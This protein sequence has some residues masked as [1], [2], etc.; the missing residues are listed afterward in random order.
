[1]TAD[2]DAYGSVG[3]SVSLSADGNTVLFG[4]PGEN[5]NVGAT[6]LFTRSG[7]TWSQVGSKW[8]STGYVGS[9]QQGSSVGLSG[10]G[11][12][13][14]VGGVL[15]NTKVAWIFTLPNFCDA[16][17]QIRTQCLTVSTSIQCRICSSNTTSSTPCK[18]MLLVY[19]PPEFSVVVGSF[20]SVVYN[21]TNVWD[22]TLTLQYNSAASFGSV[23]VANQVTLTPNT[24]TSVT[25]IVNVGSN[26]ETSSDVMNTT[27]PFQV[28][29]TSMDTLQFQIPISFEMSTFLST[30]ES[31]SYVMNLGQSSQTTTLEPL[32]R[33]S[34]YN[35]Q[36]NS[37]VIHQTIAE[38]N[39]HNIANWLSFSTNPSPLIPRTM[40]RGKQLP[41]YVDFILSF[42]NNDTKILALVGNTSVAAPT[43]TTCFIVNANLVNLGVKVN[44]TVTVDVKV[45]QSC[46]VGMSS[47][48]G[49]NDGKG[50]KVCDTPGSYQP[51]IGQTACLQCPAGKF[52]LANRT[53]CAECPPGFFSTDGSD[54][55][56]PCSKGTYTTSSNTKVCLTCAA[57]SRVTRNG[58]SCDECPPGF[59]SVDGSDM[60]LPCPLGTFTSSSNTKVCTTCS[61]G[62]RVTTNSSKCEVCPPGTFS[63]DG[64][65]VCTLC[66]I[67]KYSNTNASTAC[68]ACPESTRTTFAMGAQTLSECVPDKEQ[69]S[70]MDNEGKP[71]T[72]PIGA[73]CNQVGLTIKTLM[74]K[75]KYWRSSNESLDIRECL[76]KP[77]FCIGGHT[78]RVSARSLQ[79]VPNNN[80]TV[81]NNNTTSTTQQQ[82]DVCYPHHTGIYC[83]ACDV[84]YVHRGPDRYCM[85][86]DDA[87]REN[88]IN[89]IGGI[90]FGLFL[91]IIAV[92]GLIPTRILAKKVETLDGST[93]T[94]ASK[95]NKM[96]ESLDI[97]GE[98]VKIVI[99]F[100]Q[101]V[102]AM[103]VSF[104]SYL[105]DFF[106]SVAG[107]L[108]VL[109]FDLSQ[110]VDFGCAVPDQSHFTGLLISTLVPFGVACIVWLT[111]Q[112]TRHVV[113]K[114]R[115]ELIP[116]LNVAVNTIYLWIAFLVYPGVSSKILRTFNCEEFDDGSRALQSDATVDCNSQR[117]QQY[118]G[119]AVFM[120]LIYVVGIPVTFFVLLKRKRKLLHM[121]QWAKL[122]PDDQRTCLLERDAIPEIQS[123]HF[124][125]QSYNPNAY[126]YEIFDLLRKLAQTSIFVL[127]SK[128]S[129]LQALF[130]MWISIVTMSVLS[131]IRPYR[132]ASIGYLASW[133]QL[134][135]LVIAFLSFVNTYENRE[136]SVGLPPVT[137]GTV[138]NV[139]LVLSFFSV[140][141]YALC[142]K[143]YDV[144][145]T[146]KYGERFLLQHRM[147]AKYLGKNNEQQQ[148]QQDNNNR[149]QDNFINTNDVVL[150]IHQKKDDV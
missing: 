37:S 79:E 55:C 98:Q 130:V 25:V 31:F 148:N 41:H 61:A 142:S 101:V 94:T 126:W 135:I 104:S 112:I 113:E 17:S 68:T 45:L 70:Y 128:F 90:I 24:W 120:F 114:R 15:S 32:P 77:K 35:T 87:N 131:V 106:K 85:E 105:P 50:C 149:I 36:S 60:C 6:W 74:I 78:S 49:T 67:G 11:T 33:V 57:G 97:G 18:Q 58:T 138:T 93:R 48:S 21:I 63:A 64:S 96:L 5:S 81:N 54:V 28:T 59:F 44:R 8:V 144:I 107:A 129:P 143:L 53:G 9:P 122:S 22:T 140:P 65:D 71:K 118:L 16:T 82:N 121:S 92:L 139:I 145:I 89:K 42:P 110:F 116:D 133:S 84:G 51:A 146:S 29:I 7:T 147:V 47:D 132:E 76:L 115:P 108:G 4:G 150:S 72:C 123:L 19:S 136:A 91:A 127:V 12:T 13:A 34:V 27:F 46:P 83:Q 119:Y 141:V 125:W 23:S 102:S 10:D 40:N 66:E 109:A 62:S 124:L 56:N 80:D 137:D 26:V 86:C 100:L 20:A 117:Y 69:N 1:V 75:P 52:P 103:S 95:V 39:G 38:C 88:D 3:T 2:G 30:P 43:L 14:V 134:S 111:Y 73:I 99:G